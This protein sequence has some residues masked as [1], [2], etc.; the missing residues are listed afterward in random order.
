MYIIE[1]VHVQFKVYIITIASCETVECW[2]V[3][4]HR[5]GERNSGRVTGWWDV[6]IKYTVAA[7]L[8]CDMFTL[9]LHTHHTVII[10]IAR[11]R[12]GG[13]IVLDAEE[14]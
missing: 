9:L 12:E 1:L 6:N 10:H 8:L 2:Q 14:Q 5:L 13:E 11:E 3:R 7:T 4:D